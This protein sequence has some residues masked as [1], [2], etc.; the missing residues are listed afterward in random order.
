MCAWLTWHVCP[1]GTRTFRFPD[2]VLKQAWCAAQNAY[3]LF[4]DSSHTHNHVGSCDT[5][6][7]PQGDSSDFL[8]HLQEHLARLREV[9]GQFTM[10]KK[11]SQDNC[12]I[13]FLISTWNKYSWPG[14]WSIVFVYGS[15][16]TLLGLSLAKE[17]HCPGKIMEPPQRALTRRKLILCFRNVKS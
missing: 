6:A 1:A 11:S 14:T 9:R 17:T 5:I 8:T 3:I 16:V 15:G 13:N 4:I 2:S 12:Q 7:W 10:C